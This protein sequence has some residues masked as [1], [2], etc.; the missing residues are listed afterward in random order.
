MSDLYFHIYV[1]KVRTSYNSI[2][3]FYNFHI[4]GFQGTPRAIANAMGVRRT[5]REKSAIAL[6][7]V[8]PIANAMGVRRTQQEKSTIALWGV[9]F[10]SIALFLYQK[11]PVFHF[12]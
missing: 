4:W 10:G 1:S 12:E 3:T 8:L 2:P 9:L 11:L 7:G 5:Q 6:G